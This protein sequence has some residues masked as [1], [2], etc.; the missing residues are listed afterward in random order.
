MTIMHYRRAHACGGTF[1]F[2]VNLADRSSHMLV[3]HI[4]ALRDAVRA[5]KQRH[6][7]EIVAWVVLRD[8]MHAVWTLPPD[9]KDFST[10]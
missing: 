6:A 8:H 3:E 5:V 10:R 1:F 4:D 2:T 9:D 7:F